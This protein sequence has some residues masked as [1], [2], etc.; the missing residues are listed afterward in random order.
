MPRRLWIAVVDD[1]PAFRGSVERLLRSVGYNVETFASAEKFLA[2]PRYE[3]TACLV[4]DVHMLGMTGIELHQHLLDCGNSIPT[5][6]ITAFF[7]SEQEKLSLSNGA[8]CYLH[9]PCDDDELVR[10]IR[11]AVEGDGR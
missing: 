5:I 8:V 2:F 6:L 7:D 4:S 11:I 9:K 10:C 1:D 3:E